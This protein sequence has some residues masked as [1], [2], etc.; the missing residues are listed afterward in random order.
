MP[1]GFSS[2]RSDANACPTPAS[3]PPFTRVSWSDFTCAQTSA[4]HFD[5]QLVILHRGNN[6]SPLRP[7]KLRAKKH[8]KNLPYSGPSVL[9]KKTRPPNLCA[10]EKI[11][12]WFPFVPDR[13]GLKTNRTQNQCL[14]TPSS[15]CSSNKQKH[16]VDVRGCT[17]VSTTKT[18]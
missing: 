7:S 14:S 18:C 2:N 10:K 16:V 13:S 4:D 15:I 11:V 1:W 12:D 5:F 17:L 3:A 9:H 8:Q 6:K